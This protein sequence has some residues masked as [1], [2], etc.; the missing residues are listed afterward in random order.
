M[1]DTAEKAR[2]SDTL[3]ASRHSRSQ[4]TKPTEKPWPARGGGRHDRC[5]GRGVPDQILEQKEAVPGKAGEQARVSSVR[6]DLKPAGTTGRRGE[7]GLARKWAGPSDTCVG[8]VAPAP[9][10]PLH[11][12][13]LQA[14]HRARREN[15][16]ALGREC[17]RAPAWSAWPAWPARGRRLT[18]D[19][20]GQTERSGQRTQKLCLAGDTTREGQATDS[21][22]TPTTRVSSTDSE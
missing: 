6:T 2:V 22:A 9:T 17:G 1:K 4:N 18:Q 20:D 7:G 14:D 19:R 5:G 13:H 11:G 16:K 15:K 3:W 10:C 21:G 12:D 8:N